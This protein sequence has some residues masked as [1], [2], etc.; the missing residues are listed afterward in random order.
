[1][2]GRMISHY[3]VLQQLGEG[4]MG[5]V[6]KAHDS[7]LDRTVALKFLPDHLGGDA[8]EKQRFIREA[9]SASALNHNNICS[10]HSIEETEEGNIFIV[11][12]YYEGVSL[13]QRVE[14]SPL[15]VRD[16]L[17]YA[18]EIASGLQKAHEKEIVHRDLKPANIFLTTDDQIKIIDF[19]LA[20]ASAQTMLT[21]TGS[22]LGT[23]PYMSPEQARGDAVDHRTD[24]WSF[25]AVLYEMLTGQRPFKSEYET[26]LIYS[27][28]N[29]DPEPVTAVRSGIPMDLERVI[30]KCLEKDPVNRYQHVNEISV[31]LRRIERQLSSGQ[32]AKEIPEDKKSRVRDDAGT[33]RLIDQSVKPGTRPRRLFSVSVTGFVFLVSFVIGM[34]LYHTFFK[35]AETQKQVTLRQITFAAGV[36]EYPAWSPD[37]TRIAFSREVDGFWNIFIKNIETGD[38]RQVTTVNRDNIQPV[39]SPDGQNL[40]FVRSNQPH[41]KIGLSDIFGWHDDGDVWELNLESMTER[42]FIDDAYNPTYSPDGKWVAVDASWAGP[43]R[44]WVVDE[45]GRNPRQISSDISEAVVHTMP[46]WSPDGSKIV[47]QHIEGTKRDIRVIDRRTEEISWV[48]DDHFTNIEPY[49]SSADNMIYFSS[50]RGGGMNIWR[51]SVETDNPASPDRFEQITTGAGQDINVSPSPDGTK[52][53]F[54]VL[55]LN[56]DIWLLPVSPRDG[57][58]T[59]APQPLIVTTREDSRGA[60]SPD[61]RTIA[62]NSDRTGD[63]NIWL[64]SRDDGSVRQLTR[65]P[66]GDYQPNWSPDGTEITFFS[67]RGGHLDIWSVEVKTGVL[68]QLTNRAASDINPFYSPDGNHIAFHSDEEGRM[69]PWVMQSDGSVLRRLAPITAGL[70]F[71]RWTQDG[72]GVIFRSQDASYQGLWVAPLD[73]TEPALF[74]NPVG[75]A[76]ISFS[77]DYSMIADVVN[78]QVIWITPMA[79]GEAYDV[80]EFDDPEVRIDYPVWSPDGH[81]II[82]DRSRPSGGNI[83]LAEGLKR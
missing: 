79:D 30:S 10:I 52:I 60:W 20:K 14:Q 27:I 81:Y 29:E 56:S 71:M 11:M 73:G 54:S 48:T 39:W 47:F 46:R 3:K 43:R 64:Y 74:G 1:M 36:D 75:G 35:A 65:G 40:L 63:M 24:I 58:P 12:A 77:P 6:Y 68:E 7:K 5:V 15:P 33:G 16:A 34:Y 8:E 53:A 76:H 26:A 70:H 17:R 23:V 67:S 82:F 38:E 25:G 57:R 83:W 28:I 9:K 45:R 69:E 80:F 61:G 55:G 37:G 21:K 4:G 31:D 51:V 44:L 50:Y 18:I 42:K 62:F 32:V 13:K 66:G 22:T 59:G 49:W 72:S 41:G 2:I 19:G 78:H